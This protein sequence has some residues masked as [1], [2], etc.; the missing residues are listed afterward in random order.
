MFQ[1]RDCLHQIGAFDLRFQ[2]PIHTW[3]NKRH[4]T[5][6]AKKLDRCLVNNA[7][8]AT[9]P[10]ASA[11]FLPP[12][13][14]DHAPCLIDL[15]F[16]LPKS[17]T[18]P[19]KFLNYLTKH[20]NF[21]EVV[22]DA[23]FQAGGVSGNLTSLCWKLKS[24]K[25]N[26]KSLNREFSN[27]QQRVRETHGLL[28]LAQVQALVETFEAELLLNQKWQLL[29]QIE[30][31][32]YKQKSRIH[33]LLEGDQNTTYFKRVCQVCASFN[34]IRS[35]ILSSG[36]IIIETMQMSDHAINHFKAVLGP[37]GA[38]PLLISSTTLWFQSLSNFICSPPQKEK[39]LLMPTSDE[40]AKLMFS[41]NPKKLPDLMASP[42]LFTRLHGLSLVQ[43][44][45]IPSSIS[46]SQASFPNQPTPQS[47]H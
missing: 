31:S 2:G 11:S 37:D 29:R 32:F 21:L 28:Q 26:L 15:A 41:L 19:Y 34:A 12:V 43:S 20:P 36:V 42:Q 33:C 46:S 27:I 35:F 4:L 18:Q 9:F 38:L 25:R 23:W 13:P 6:V 39:I 5:P 44:V 3:S 45:S 40:I 17:G 1:L 30:E 7:V 47:S 10:H 22:T 16:P 14:P 24:I 8:L